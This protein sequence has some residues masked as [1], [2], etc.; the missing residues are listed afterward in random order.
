[1]LL[2]KWVY[3]YLLCHM[4][5]SNLTTGQW[6]SHFPLLGFVWWPRRLRSSSCRLPPPTAPHRLP[7]SGCHRGPAQ[8]ALPTPYSAGRGA[9]QQP[10][11]PWKH[12]GT[13][14]GPDS[15]GFPARGCRHSKLSVQHSTSTAL[16]YWEEDPAWEPGDRSNRECF[17]R[18]GE[19]QVTIFVTVFTFTWK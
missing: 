12:P 14:Q 4:C 15:S 11:P 2:I 1:M 3:V 19:S 6:R 5:S 8:P 17:Q 7:A 9:R 16:L 10:L 18:D 13:S